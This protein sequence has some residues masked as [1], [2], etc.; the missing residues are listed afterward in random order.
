[1]NK[2][3]P[4]QRA[5]DELGARGWIVGLRRSQAISR[6]HLNVLGA[7]GRLS[8]GPPDRRLERQARLRL[9]HPPRPAVPPALDGRVRLDRRLAHVGQAD[10]RRGRG[11]DPLLRPEA[12]V[13]PA[14]VVGPGRPRTAPAGAADPVVAKR[15]AKP[16]G[17]RARCPRC[18]R[19]SRGTRSR[20]AISSSL[21][22]ALVWLQSL[23]APQ[24]KQLPV[25]RV[26]DAA[27]SR[28]GSRRS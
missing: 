16:A 2:V 14:R 27:S 23:L 26:Q 17:F 28:A 11:G 8:Q 3:E 25:L 15:T 4:M 20:S 19:C 13:R 10:G 5:L 22:L 24:A 18:R 9:P 21:A 12:G 1:M 6:H 7:A